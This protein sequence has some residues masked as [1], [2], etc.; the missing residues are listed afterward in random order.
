MKQSVVAVLLL[1]GLLAP[2]ASGAQ[3][4]Q[5]TLLC[6]PPR[7]VCYP[8]GTLPPVN[9]VCSQNFNSETP[10]ASQAALTAP[11]QSTAPKSACSA[12]SV[13][14]EETQSYEWEMDCG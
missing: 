1:A 2:H 14:N 11:S 5:C 8:A 13:F 3:S 4:I 12:V 7:M 9:R 6:N 10:A